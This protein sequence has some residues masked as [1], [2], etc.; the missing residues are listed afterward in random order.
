[1]CQCKHHYCLII[2]D[3][4]GDRELEALMYFRSQVIKNFVIFAILSYLIMLHNAYLRPG[5]YVL[6][7]YVYN[8]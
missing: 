8:E 5:P 7:V 2:G 1:M 4:H 3:S 6:K